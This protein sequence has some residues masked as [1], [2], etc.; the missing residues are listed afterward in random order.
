M[1]FAIVGMLLIAARPTHGQHRLDLTVEEPEVR[2]SGRAGEVVGAVGIESKTTEGVPPAPLPLRITSGSISH[3]ELRAHS[4]VVFE[5]TLT[6]VGK[7]PIDVPWA[8]L[9]DHIHV[10][11]DEQALIL[12]IET[13]DVDKKRK[14][15]A[16]T[17][18]LGVPS[19]RSLLR[20]EP[21]ETATIRNAVEMF[22]DPADIFTRPDQTSDVRF[23][24]HI[25]RSGEMTQ[26]VISEP[27]VV[28]V[29]KEPK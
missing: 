19:S 28:T 15:L 20:L 16:S 25:R 6:N 5:V 26:E 12:T 27:I 8:P 11:P 29:V 23:A 18:L 2:T 10:D 9:K 4:K 7:S 21:S 22:F 3:T 14:V 13:V 1:S 24:F 17:I